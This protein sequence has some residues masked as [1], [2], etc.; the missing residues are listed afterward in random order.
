MNKYKYKIKYE[1]N[2]FGLHIRWASINENM[3]N[4]HLR[5]SSHLEK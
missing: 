4:G 1:M 5:G 2:K 3:T